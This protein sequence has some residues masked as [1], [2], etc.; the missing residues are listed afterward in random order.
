VA[1][2]AT[3]T[4]RS[5]P[6][7][8]ATIAATVQCGDPRPWIFTAEVD[9][10][11]VQPIASDGA[12]VLYDVSFEVAGTG[13]RYRS[14]EL[15][16][17]SVQETTDRGTAWSV[18]L[19]P[20]DSQGGRR[21]LGVELQW[22]APP[23]GKIPVDLKIFYLSAQGE[24]EYVVVKGG[25][26]DSSDR[27][28]YPASMTIQGLGKMGHYDRKRVTLKIPARSGMYH[29]QI[30]I[31][32]A[33]Q[34]GV[35][36]GEIK[37]SPTLGAPRLKPYDIINEDFP[38]V[39]TEVAES[40]GY[41]VDFDRSGDFVAFEL[42]PSGPP[43]AT[44]T[45]KAIRADGSAGARAIGE[46]PT[47]IIFEG[48]GPEGQ[49]SAAGRVRKIREV[50]VY[51]ELVLE[52]AAYQQDPISGALAALGVSS[53]I[54]KQ[55][56]LKLRTTI[57][58]VYQD[59]CLEQRWTTEESHYNPTAARYQQGIS[60]EPQVYKRVHVF[61]VGAVVD[62][63]TDAFLW[64]IAKFV[65]TKIVA[66]GFRYDVAGRLRRVDTVYAQWRQREVAVKQRA[67]ASDDWESQ[68]FIDNQRIEAGGR[69]VVYD[70]EK[71]FEGRGFST[72]SVSG[73]DGRPSS[74]GTAM[75]VDGSRVIMWAAVDTKEVTNTVDNFVTAEVTE[76]LGIGSKE[77]Y[78]Y[79]F[80]G[81]SEHEED[82]EKPG[83]E[84][85]GEVVL[86]DAEE[87]GGLTTIS[88]P[89]LPG[90]KTGDQTIERGDGYL[91]A[92][93]L[94]DGELSDRASN[95]LI[96]VEICAFQDTHAEYEERVSNDFVESVAEARAYVVREFKRRVPP[97][98][99]FSAPISAGIERGMVLVVYVPEADIDH[100]VWVEQADHVVS[101]DGQASTQALGI[102]R[103]DL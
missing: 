53:P 85:G 56:A 80:H 103:I 23:P 60:G 66:E 17:W 26:S 83:Y 16:A 89:T 47:C 87:G 32:L 54:V 86:Y 73:W 43:V 76:K 9:A 91:P 57:E 24:A 81:G 30:L 58:E 51:G 70:A 15:S 25:I 99:V 12:P 18:T 77:G 64:P 90:G 7:T 75:P 93:E 37:I 22:T 31:A 65:P 8:H 44:F 68:D 62:D 48:S 38:V 100:E 13:T 5:G 14:H 19:A 6:Q 95:T 102:V 33:Q 46:V 20:Y 40:C 61:D 94:C 71:W 79:L 52:Y 3:A 98:V 34:A 28:I 49:P 101:A 42:V 10:G 29:G 4:V 74:P 1:T 21:A 63:K 2:V 27:T 82:E 88:T 39:A 11:D 78:Q 72:S 41:G 67:T 84:A 59:G 97:R 69:G 55:G 92:S 96:E 45:P 35:P 50:S 36:A